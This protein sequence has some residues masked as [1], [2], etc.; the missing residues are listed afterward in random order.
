[1]AR[2]NKK[3]SIGSRKPLVKELLFIEGIGRAGK[4]L[5]ANILHSFQGIEPVQCRGLLDNIPFLEKFGLI[6]KKV[7]QEIL[8]CEIDMYCYEMIIGRNLNHRLSDKSSIFNVPNYNKY[9]KRCKE[10]DGDWALQRFYK[11]KLCSMFILHDLIPNIKIYFDTF[12]ELKVL[13]VQS[14]PVYLVYRWYKRGLGR[15]FDNDPKLF[16]LM[17]SEE[18]KNVP[19]YV[20]GWA[21]QY[22]KL[23]EMD[24]CIAMI[25]SITHAYKKSYRQLSPQYKK[26]ILFVSYESVLTNPNQ[27]IGE[28]KNFLGRQP[29]KNGMRAV[30][31]HEKLP[32][33]VYSESK[34]EKLAFIKENSSEDYFKRLLTLEKEYIKN[35]K[36]V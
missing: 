27:I 10:P 33:L 16:N 21:K 15:R 34:Q 1:M 25:E 8:Q 9:L 14:D 20:A 7:A 36:A 32:N 4:F 2:I 30:F 3:I 13:S 11:E 24:R 6:D 26:K 17:L 28:I 18:G 22:A 35:G 29:I 12:P 23:S 31:K 19:W 5:L